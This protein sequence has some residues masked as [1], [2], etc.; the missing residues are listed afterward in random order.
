V[1]GIAQLLVT[2]LD[3][4]RHLLHRGADPAQILTLNN[5]P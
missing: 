5:G 4:R 2:F 3:R 1:I